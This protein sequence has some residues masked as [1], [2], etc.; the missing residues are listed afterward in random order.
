VFFDGNRA[1]PIS[2]K[3]ALPLKMYLQAEQFCYSMLLMSVTL[4]DVAYDGLRRKLASGELRAGQRIVNR[5]VAKELKVSQTPLR[6]ALN[7]LASEGVVEYI[8]G[9]GA[10]VSSISRQELLDLYDLREHIEPFAAAQAARQITEAEI[11]EL[12][13]LCDDWL[14][15]A[16]AIR[17]DHRSKANPEE[18]ARWN[19][20]EERFHALL[21]DA[22]RNRWL[23]R[24]VKNLRVLSFAFAVQRQSPQLLGLH[25]AAITWRDHLRIVRSLER[26]DAEG[27]ERIVQKHIATGRGHMVRAFRS[28]PERSER[29][30]PPLL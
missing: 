15:I 11:L 13:N 10:Y 18:M 17:D 7:R 24:I 2:S 28:H 9:A 6:E 16:R 8:P 27:A 12:H 22:S 21:L 20:N 26:R 1:R 5:T 29:L 25:E 19:D 23:V 3:A 4:T 30:L 14:R